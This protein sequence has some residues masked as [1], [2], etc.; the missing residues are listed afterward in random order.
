MAPQP[1]VSSFQF[2]TI[3]LAR[4]L[5][6]CG[7]SNQLQMSGGLS[8]VHLSP[9][10]P[11]DS[12][13]G[14]PASL[15]FSHVNHSVGFCWL[16]LFLFFPPM[17]PYSFGAGEKISVSFSLPSWFTI[18][19]R[20]AAF[21]LSHFPPL[22][23]AYAS[24]CTQNKRWTV[25][26]FLSF[27]LTVLLE[28]SSSGQTVIQHLYQNHTGVFCTSLP[29]LAVAIVYVTQCLPNW[30]DAKPHHKHHNSLLR[31][32]CINQDKTL[33][34]CGRNKA[35]VLDKCDLYVFSVQSR[36]KDIL[37]PPLQ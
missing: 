28:G 17:F 14:M 35:A 19:S 3:S 25:E 9:L 27:N 10:S 30:N 21:W 31:V 34:L 6:V 16:F 18:I 4:Q 2:H 37:S 5:L 15:L 11:R 22:L 7:A 32:K 1:A 26:K 12:H 29:E 13:T 20:G 23:F 8:H 24:R 33:H 36:K